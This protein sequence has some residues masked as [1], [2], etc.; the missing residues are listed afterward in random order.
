[1]T[2]LRSHRR[3]I[4]RDRTINGLLLENLG[5]QTLLTQL[6]EK[7]LQLFRDVY[8]TGLRKI[9]RRAS[10]LKCDGK[11]VV[12]KKEYVGSQRYE[13][14]R[15]KKENTVG[16]ICD[17]NCDDESGGGDNVYDYNDSRFVSVNYSHV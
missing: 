17:Y 14:E 15:R 6:E 11:K 4:R 8:R 5:I 1:M 7:Q 3:E 13:L 9:R 2:F 10:E 12:G 16:E